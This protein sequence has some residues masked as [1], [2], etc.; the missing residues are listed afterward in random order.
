M[1][2]LGVFGKKRLS[3]HKIAAL[4]HLK[5]SYKRRGRITLF[6]HH[7]EQDTKTMGLI[8]SEADLDSVSE[9]NF[10]AVRRVGQW[11]RLLKGAVGSSSVRVFDGKLDKKLPGRF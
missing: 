9:I 5:G 4:K 1:R 2:E 6:P 11:N 3:G 10:P 7:R 8:C